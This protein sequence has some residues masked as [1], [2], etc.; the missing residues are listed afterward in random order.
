M[1]ASR[2]NTAKKQIFTTTTIIDLQIIIFEKVR[3]RSTL[4]A[5]INDAFKQSPSGFVGRG[6]GEV[7]EGM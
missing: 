7:S 4:D 5:A 2:G 3:R 1:T 6:G